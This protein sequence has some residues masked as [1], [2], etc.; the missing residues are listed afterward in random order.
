MRD[1]ETNLRKCTD[2]TCSRCWRN[3]S[4]DCYIEVAIR[5]IRRYEQAFEIVEKTINEEKGE[6]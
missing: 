3:G 4:K 1:L 6:A 5:T 2:C